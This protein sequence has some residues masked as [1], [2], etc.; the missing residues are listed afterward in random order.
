MAQRKHRSAPP[1]LTEILRDRRREIIAEWE[2]VFRE[3]PIARELD[4]PTLV[5][6][7]PSFLDRIVLITEELQ[8]GSVPE[9]PLRAAEIHAVGRLDRGF[10]LEQ[11]V[12]ELAL[13]RD[14][15][16]T[17]MWGDRGHESELL[18]DL[19]ILNQAIDKAVTATIRRYTE[20][21]DRSM[22][23]FDRIVTAAV[24]MANLDDLLERLLDVLLDST[25]PDVDLAL[26][27][28]REGD[29]LR[30]RA[31]V[32]LEVDTSFA[33]RIGNGFIG[34]IASDHLARALTAASV[35]PTLDH[36][37]LLAAG[38]RALYGVPL[39]AGRDV[40]GVGLIGSLTAN[41]FSPQ[42]SQ[43]LEVVASRA[44][45]AIF[46][47][48]LR[49]TAERNARLLH[50]RELQ[51]QTLADNIPQLAWMADR[52]GAVFWFNRRWFEFTG[53]TL[54]QVEGSGWQSVHHPD[55]VKDV[56]DKFEQAIQS[57]EVWEDTFP[58]RAK[59]G[60]YR[61]FLSRAVPIRDPE[62]KVTRWFGT[63]TDITEQRFLAEAT[64]VLGSSL[65][66]LQTLEKLA[67]LVVPH[68]ADWCLVDIVEE[69]GPRRLAVVH[70]D[71]AKLELAR[72]WARKYPPDWSEPRGSARVLRTG[73][74][75]M[76]HEI[77]EE[78]LIAA[79]RDP[80]QLA[81][82]R[83]LG[84]ASA[85]VVPLVGREGTLGAL[86]LLTS[87]SGRHYQDSDLEVAV[88]LGRRAGVAIEHARL[89]RDARDAVRLREQIL[90]IVSH[91]L[92][93]P[94]GTIDLTASLV[95][96]DPSLDPELRRRLDIVRRSA[97]RMQRMIGD[98]LDLARAQSAT[99]K[100]DRKPEDADEMLNGIVEINLPIA[101]DKGIT[102]TKDSNVR[103]VVV[104]CDCDRI[105][106]VF[107]NLLGN[108]IKFCSKGDTISLG[109]TREGD[110]VR[111]VV[112]DTGPG[113]PAAELPHVFDP[114]WSSRVRAKEG[115]GLGLYIAKGIVEAHGG[116]MWAESAPGAGAT[117][118]VRLRVA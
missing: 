42:D 60:R 107:G 99:F 108:A 98:L 30:V 49:E 19:R 50:E 45:S 26:I 85:I 62:G 110:F 61:W 113:I 78:L 5:D 63:S 38:I 75:E 20:A 51:L 59:D 41:Q 37:S 43:L 1:R 2:D 67:Q 65:D 112:A 88:E 13:L 80:E 8:Q 64:K 76:F 29:V 6:Q 86:T 16:I 46:Q 32:G 81:P 58:L 7:M 100:L 15:I 111:Y 93:N 95:A 11:I 82:L 102:L 116:E 36:P 24:E 79:A 57:G 14:C 68:L 47:H 70:R 97:G 92:R 94:L 17:R 109:A 106:Q 56:V 72:E 39:V 66:Y 3:F 52:T 114:Y 89:Y 44:S 71:P 96:E 9:L 77:T 54:E 23:A 31:A 115:L 22:Q 90:A 12:I 28:L 117:F 91:D 48:M 53:T 25:T 34:T 27:A 40:I 10:D 83:A 35:D 73:Q 4:H 101:R 74:P 105:D 103:G 55:H 87:E 104:D 118:V 69:N 33:L 84:L 18:L 21:R